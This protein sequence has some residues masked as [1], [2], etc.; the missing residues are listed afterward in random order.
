MRKRKK[1][2]GKAAQEYLQG[3]AAESRRRSDETK[4][5]LAIGGVI[6]VGLLVV[7][8]IRAE[9]RSSAVRANAEAELIRTR[10]DTALDRAERE[11]NSLDPP[12]RRD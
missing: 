11:R 5:A 2:K 10:V 12:P 9:S 4:W 1:P 3:Q 6:G 7:L 8:W